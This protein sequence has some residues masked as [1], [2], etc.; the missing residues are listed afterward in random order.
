MV[1]YMLH[2]IKKIL[3]HST[4][5]QSLV[6]C[7]TLNCVQYIKANQIQSALQRIVT[8]KHFR[9]VV[10]VLQCLAL[11]PH[12]K[13]VLGSTPAGRW[14][15]LCRVCMF[16]LYLHGYSAFSPFLEL[17][18]LC[19]SPALAWSLVQGVTCLFL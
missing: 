17:G 9:T 13:K 3:C 1:L 11:L 14:T 2:H 5:Q 18:C 4:E 16:S 19:V 7:D 10:E 15:L 6:V 8:D 12:I